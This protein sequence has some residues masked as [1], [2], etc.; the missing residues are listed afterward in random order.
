MSKLIKLPNGNWVRACDII[1]I[2]KPSFNGN[3][4]YSILAIKNDEGFKYCD[5]KMAQLINNEEKAISYI[6]RLANRINASL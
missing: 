4:W 1:N 2:S 6:D 5:L 3:E